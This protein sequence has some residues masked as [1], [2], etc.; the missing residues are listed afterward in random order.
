MAGPLI[1]DRVSYRF[2]TRRH[3]TVHLIWKEQGDWTMFNNGL[4]RVPPEELLLN[5]GMYLIDFLAEMK[6]AASPDQAKTVIKKFIKH[7]G[8]YL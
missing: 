7:K 6:S 8:K 4:N 1:K 3:G 5:K 2:G